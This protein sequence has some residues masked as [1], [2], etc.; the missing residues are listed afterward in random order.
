VTQKI[1]QAHEVF[2]VNK[3]FEF[4]F[5]IYH[6]ALKAEDGIWAIAEK[7]FPNQEIEG[8]KNLFV[9]SQESVFLY[10]ISSN[11]TTSHEVK[12]SMLKSTS[13]IQGFFNHPNVSGDQ[14]EESS[15]IGNH[16]TYRKG[17]HN[18]MNSI[19]IE[20][21]GACYPKKSHLGTLIQM[22]ESSL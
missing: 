11:S 4:D 10:R 1:L 3:V 8:H 14:E 2:K 18:Q 19:K 20:I 21:F 15:F 22:I 12:S 9:N 17:H 6:S 7:T 16:S 5:P 13:N